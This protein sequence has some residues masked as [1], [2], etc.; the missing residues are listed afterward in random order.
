VSKWSTG[1]DERSG[2]LPL[3]CYISGADVTGYRATLV[4][5]HLRAQPGPIPERRSAGGTVLIM[6]L[7]SL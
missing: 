3:V 5:Q 4:T 6:G 7:G 1:C 2:H